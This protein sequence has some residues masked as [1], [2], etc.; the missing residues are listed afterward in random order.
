MNEVIPQNIDKKTEKIIK[1]V[2]KVALAIAREG[3]GALFVISNNIE[4]KNLLK[5]RLAEF[6]IF[7]DGAEKILKSIA[8]VDGAVIINKNGK[9]KDYG[10]MIRAREVLVGY[11]TRHSAGLS[12]SKHGISILCSEEEKNVKVFKEGKIIMQLDALKEDIDETIPFAT[13]L[14]ESVG[15]GAIGSLFI[16]SIYIANGIIVFG[17]TYYFI[18]NILP[19]MINKLK[20]KKK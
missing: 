13:K 17:G 4:Y 19:N 20:S 7:D 6:S 14:L 15:V 18:R 9:V 3:E 12:A 5:H 10:V 11:G 8:V 1:K 16:P 2:L